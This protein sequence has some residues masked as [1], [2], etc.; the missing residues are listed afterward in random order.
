MLDINKKTGQELLGYNKKNCPNTPNAKGAVQFQQLLIMTLPTRPTRKKYFEEAFKEDQNADYDLRNFQSVK[1]WYNDCF[2]VN[3]IPNVGPTV[4][5][6]EYYA[7]LNKEKN[8][9]AR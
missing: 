8:I 1:E 5:K 6:E 4:T 9:K 3:N 2:S 7:N